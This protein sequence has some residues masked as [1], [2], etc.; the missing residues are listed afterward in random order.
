MCPERRGKQ[1]PSVRRSFCG[2]YGGCGSLIFW[3]LS[4]KERKTLQ[5]FKCGQI[6]NHPEKKLEGVKVR[7][8]RTVSSLRET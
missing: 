8:G 2:N 3:S 1:E 4:S 7:V 5:C 6:F